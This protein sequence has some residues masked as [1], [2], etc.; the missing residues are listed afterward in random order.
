MSMARD[1]SKRRT[2]SRIQSGSY[3][4]SVR[5]KEPL[6]SEFRAYCE[7]HN[8]NASKVLRSALRVYFDPKVRRRCRRTIERHEALYETINDE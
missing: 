5:L 8:A 1:Q 3:M 7:Q 4:F 6:L 2:W